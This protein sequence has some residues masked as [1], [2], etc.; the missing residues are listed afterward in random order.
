MLENLNSTKIPI[1]RLLGFMRHH[2]ELFGRKTAAF[3]PSTDARE[4]T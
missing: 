3:R 1:E 2:F 4:L